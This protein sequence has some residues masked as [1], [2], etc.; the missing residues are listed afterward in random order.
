[1]PF[2]DESFV[3]SQKD[4]HP[5]KL[6]HPGQSWSQRVAH[7]G[8]WAFALH[9]AE[10]L[11]VLGRVFVVAVLL[12]PRDFG[13]YGMATLTFLALD[14]LSRTGFEQALIQKKEEIT[15]YLEAAWTV[16][17]IRGLLLALVVCGTA[18]WVSAFFDEPDALA[19]IRAIGLSF[20]FQGLTNIGVV[21][22]QKNLE[23]HKEFVYRFSGVLADLAVT[24]TAAYLLRNAWALVLG[25]VAADLTR[26]L[27]SY[28]IHPFR[29]RFRLDLAKSKELFGY[30]MWVD[31]LRGAYQRI[32]G[33]SA[34]LSTPAAVGIMC[35]GHDFTRI[36]LGA[37]WMPMVPALLILCAA[38]LVVSVSW[39]GRPAF[40]GRGRPETVFYIQVAM[41]ATLFLLI[42][43][44]ASRWGIIGAA[45]AM[46][47]SSASGLAV[48]YVNIRP[49]IG[50]TWKD[51]ALLFAPPL[52][53][54][55]L[56]AGA[57]FG[58]RMLTLPLLPGRHVW[59]V[60]W[61]ACMILAGVAVYF[62]LLLAFQRHLP[63]Y[64]PL[65]GIAKTLME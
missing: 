9:F 12:L 20:V 65:K 21:T 5:M 28:R 25:Y 3:V 31:R 49:Q 6:F 62:A 60:L 17:C 30:G 11:F 40:M 45:I 64:G 38:S 43:P 34:A 27:V 29:P 53:A 2:P 19:L 61:F 63:N 23:F 15:P 10:Q 13:L 33:F 32:A 56:M 24:V 41:A 7:A 26:L 1:L 4:P 55:A 58:L 18:P 50:I 48:W 57:L 39:T 59:N 42:Y 52:T 22:F 14:A 51:L 47:L 44:L 36:F 46:L 35:M 8:I 37:K 16:R 54:S